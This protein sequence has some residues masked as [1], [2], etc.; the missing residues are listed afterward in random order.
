MQALKSLSQKQAGDSQ[1]TSRAG[2]W[3]KLETARRQP[4]LE[5]SVNGRHKELIKEKIQT[6]QPML[7]TIQIQ[8][9]QC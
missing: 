9:V 1:E 4:G 8:R 7:Y 3:K 6:N 5:P 2:N